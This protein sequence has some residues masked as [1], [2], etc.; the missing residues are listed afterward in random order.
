[1]INYFRTCPCGATH[2]GINGSENFQKEHDAAHAERII[3]L[4][5]PQPVSPVYPWT[6]VNPYPNSPYQWPTITYKYNANDGFERNLS[7]LS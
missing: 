2:S 3:A 6:P 5:N 1:M 7:G 4:R